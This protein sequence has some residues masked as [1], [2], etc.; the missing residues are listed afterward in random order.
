[1]ST[2]QEDDEAAPDSYDCSMTV[3][4]VREVLWLDGQSIEALMLCCTGDDEGDRSRDYDGS[5]SKVCLFS[6]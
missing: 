4:H 5:S 6:P 2:G 1:V 3:D